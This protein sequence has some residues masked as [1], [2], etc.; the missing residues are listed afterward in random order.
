MLQ[1]LSNF[2][3]AVKEFFGFQRQRDAEHNT[4]QMQAAASAATEQQ[5]RDKTN[6][7]VATKNTQE[8]RNELAE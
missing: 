1:L 6:Q 5:Q 7:A 3:G 8:V 4:P 2:F